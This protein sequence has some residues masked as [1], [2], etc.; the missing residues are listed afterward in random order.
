MSHV[1]LEKILMSCVPVQK[2]IQDYVKWQGGGGGGQVT[3]TFYKAM[4]FMLHP[5]LD[6][7][8]LPPMASVNCKKS[9][10][11][12]YCLL[13]P[14]WHVINVHAAVLKI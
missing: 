11:C 2:Q 5:P 7:P 14:M 8:I 12:T 6:P 1:N 3:V 13:T 10:Y 4:K 9:P